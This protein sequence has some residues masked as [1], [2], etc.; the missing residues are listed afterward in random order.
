METRKLPI[1]IE[2]FEEIRT[3]GFYYIDKTLLIRE[4]LYGWGKVNLF[5]RP[6]RFGKT[7]NMSMLKAFFEIGGDKSVFND[8]AIANEKELCG[9]YMGKYPVV[10]VS[11]KSVHGLTYQHAYDMLKRVI[12][13]EASRLSFLADSPKI[14]EYDKHSYTRFRTETDTKA[15]VCDSL[16][17]LTDL[18]YKHYGQK[19]ILLIDEYDVPLNKA[20]QHG[21]YEEMLD[22][23]RTMFDSALKTNDSLRFA[24]MTGCMRVSKESIFTGLNNLK[25]HSITDAKFDEYFGFTDAEVSKL[26][27]DYGLGARRLEIKDWY[28]GY[29]FGKQDIY[30]PWNVINY[31]YDILADDAKQPQAYWLNT[32]A[33]DIV[34]RLI[35]RADDVTTQTEIE[36]LIDGES[37][38]KTLNDKLTHDEIYDNMENIWSLLF[39][40]GYLTIKRSPNMGVYELII[41]NRE[42][43]QI[44]IDQIRAWFSAKTKSETSALGD[45]YKAFEAGD[46]KTLKRILDDWLLNTISFHD[47][48]ESFYH[49][50]LLALMNTCA[51]WYVASNLETGKGR[52]DIKVERKDR[53]R[54]IIVEIKDIKD[55]NKLGAACEA[56]LNQIE[57]N[58]YTASLRRYRI[59]DIWIYGIAFCDK[60]CQVLAKHIL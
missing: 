5:T 19:A 58:D 55:P 12:R 32:S 54:G 53:K 16:R 57:N 21:Y 41:P 24:V 1:G 44:Y 17:M 30:C 18:L 7:L 2:N 40:T 23:I 51:D 15:D 33:N 38:L 60:E 6:R 43:K 59:K 4:L 34:R 26:L 11:L 27:D 31:C 49:G 10:F 14:S 42:I 8:L 47:A 45:M 35:E 28:D 46:V 50:F 37:I 36:R 48:R 3:Q 22:L 13:T 29:L 39:M 25:I 9:A 52:S 56:A 20:Y